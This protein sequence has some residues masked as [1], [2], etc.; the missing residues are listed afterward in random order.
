ML[1]DMSCPAFTKKELNSSA[2]SLGLEM[3][4]VGVTRLGMMFF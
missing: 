2:I 3:L 4:P 1:S